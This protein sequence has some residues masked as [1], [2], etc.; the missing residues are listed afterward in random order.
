MDDGL[1]ESRLI[2]TVRLEVAI[3]DE[4]RLIE[5]FR[6]SPRAA[7]TGVTQ[8]R[9]TTALMTLFDTTAITDRIAGIPGAR[10]IGGELTVIPDDGQDHPWGPERAGSVAWLKHTGVPRT[11]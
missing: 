1:V 9:P 2:L 3:E 10:P 6:A 8:A 5:A 4:D 7:A 11:R